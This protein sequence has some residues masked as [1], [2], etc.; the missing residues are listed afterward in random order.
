MGKVSK[1]SY[2][3]SSWSPWIGC[4]KV[5]EACQN[6]YAE[7]QMK[8]FGRDFSVVT[9]AANP[10]FYAPRRWLPDESE[11]IFVCEWSDFFHPAADEWRHDAWLVM[12]ST[13]GHKYLILTKRP[14]RIAEC[15]AP[16]PQW[17]L[18]WVWLGVTAENQEQADKRIPILV[19]TPAVL[20]FV[21][22]EPLL[23]PI[24]FGDDFWETGNRVD[25]VIVGAESGPHRREC[26][27]EWIKSIVNQCR[28]AQVPVYVKQGSHRFPGRQGDLPD[29]M[30]KI[31]ESPA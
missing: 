18:S 22:L 11:R 1:I 21:S 14:E 4:T 12:M 30:W 29:H 24:D 15:V 28:S 9:R 17:P 7:A 23:G 26:K 20:H 2:V 25:W 19:E 27:L 31:K 3:D 6:C 13:C 10:T 16:F 5:S 8:R